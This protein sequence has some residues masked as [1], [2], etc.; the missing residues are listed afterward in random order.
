MSI[1]SSPESR[2]GESY[3]Y[4]QEVRCTLNERLVAEA[5]LR[6]SETWGD[7][8]ALDLVLGDI[9]LLDKALN[10][11][12]DRSVRVRAQLDTLDVLTETGAAITALRRGNER[13]FRDCWS[14]ANVICD[15]NLMFFSP[16]PQRYTLAIFLSNII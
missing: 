16:P 1:K 5:D 15:E 13:L 3:W 2:D 6:Q 7:D 12:L 14:R 10:E 11:Q 4:W 9:D 8:N